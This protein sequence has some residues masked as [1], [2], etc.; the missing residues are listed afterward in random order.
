MET[1][2]ICPHCKSN[3]VNKYG[4]YSHKRSHKIIQRYLCKKCSSTFSDQT[5]S[6]LYLQHRPDLNEKILGAVSAGVG[7]RR[8]AF[9]F[10]TNKKTVQRKIKFLAR[11]CDKFHKKFMTQA[12][13]DLTFQFDDLE[14]CE[15]SSHATVWVPVLAEKKSHFIVGSVA[16]Y[17]TSKSHYPKLQDKHNLKH[18]EEIDQWGKIAKEQIKLCRI[19]Q[20]E[21]VIVIETD[22]WRSYPRYMREVF[23]DQ[24]IH[25]VYTSDEDKKNLFP[26]NNVH[27]CLRADKAMLRRD[28]WHVCKNKNFLS[29]HLKI[30][31]FYSNYMKKKIYSEKYEDENGKKKKRVFAV[32]TPAMQLGIFTKPIQ[33]QFLLNNL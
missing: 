7:I 6:P 2:I 31:I 16:Q 24:G 14:T 15:H 23:G 29:D 19:M 22:E 20:P 28:T 3:L 30:Y 11:V 27:A 8:T 5:L 10:K 21:G 12:K 25:L 18:K 9:L 26:I 17:V 4:S 33:L 32:E 13:K 1:L